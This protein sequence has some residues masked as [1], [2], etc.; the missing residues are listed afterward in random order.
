MKWML[1]EAKRFMNVTRNEDLT[2]RI[3]K[4]QILNLFSRRRSGTVILILTECQDEHG[5]LC[6]KARC[7]LNI[8]QG[9]VKSI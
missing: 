2:R 4:T 3:L 5:K 8:P 7:Q 1:A 6:M 9:A